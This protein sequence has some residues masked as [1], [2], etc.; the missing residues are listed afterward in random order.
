MLKKILLIILF[1]N[2]FLNAQV[3]T[4]KNTT[5]KEG[6]GTGLS[7]EEAVSNALSEAIGQINGVYIS[8]KTITKNLSI[9]SSNGDSLNFKYSNSINRIT[10]GKVDSYKILDVI[11][12]IDNMYEAT[13][14]VTKTKITKNYKVPGLDKKKRRSIAI[15]PPITKN[16]SYYISGKEF[17]SRDTSNSLSHE[18]VNSITKTRKFNVLDRDNLNAYLKEKRVILNS[19]TS[20]EEILKLGKVISAD[21]LLVTKIIQLATEKSNAKYNVAASFNSASKYNLATT[22]EYRIIAMATRQ[23]KWSN[24]I[25]QSITINAN[26]EDQARLKVT[27]KLADKIKVELLENIYPVKILRVDKNDIYIN[28]GSLEIGS[29]YNVFSMGEKLYDPYTKEYIGRAETQSGEIEVTRSIAK[30]SV[31]KYIKG[32]VKKSDVCRLKNIVSQN[33]L[34]PKDFGGIRTKESGGVSLP[35]D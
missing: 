16:N 3:I 25:N 22:I 14:S 19:D 26:S 12:N 17:S 18:I 1:S 4:L 35:F 24:T 28:Q 20:T 33:N 9:E 13:V 21:Y 27:Q 34:N 7:R 6:V 30:Y 11:K 23:I 32:T 29:K 31:A 8:N 5:S 15:L 2:Y 10:K